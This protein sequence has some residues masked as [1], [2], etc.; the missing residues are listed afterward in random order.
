MRFTYFLL[1]ALV[2]AAGCKGFSKKTEIDRFLSQNDWQKDGADSKSLPSKTALASVPTSKESTSLASRQFKLSSVDSV[3]GSGLNDLKTNPTPPNIKD[4]EYRPLHELPQKK[5]ETR[6]VSANR[7]DQWSNPLRP[8][9]PKTRWTLRELV[10][11]WS[12]ELSRST[13]NAEKPCPI[14]DCDTCQAK[15]FKDHQKFVK[16]APP[17]PVSP[18]NTN[19]LTKT[20]SE[21]AQ[22]LPGPLTQHIA[23][24]K[25]LNDSN[26]QITSSP[27]PAM[28]ICQNRCNDDDCV[29]DTTMIKKTGYV[30]TVASHPPVNV[31]N[32]PLEDW[33][34]SETP[35]TSD[36]NEHLTQTLETL[37]NEV[38]FNM[39]NAN[40]CKLR[41]LRLLAGNI[42]Q[43]T[44]PINTISADAQLAFAAQMSAIEKMISLAEKNWDKANGQQRIQ[45][46]RDCLSHLK[47]AVAAIASH[48]PLEV[49]NLQACTEIRGFGQ[50]TTAGKTQNTNADV[51]LYCEIENLTNKKSSSKNDVRFE[52]KIHGEVEIVDEKG[53][54]I[55]LQE[56]PAI[57]DSSRRIRRDFFIYFPIRTPQEPGNYK[58]IARIRDLN[59]NAT[60]EEDR[61]V[62]EISTELVVR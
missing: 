22:L 31:I 20:D 16:A 44:E 28:S 8:R 39:D 21:L 48:A 3:I 23:E 11:V 25:P 49:A 52:T 40:P 24:Q 60:S 51:L 55:K 19:Q 32:D 4:L 13:A 54:R 7:S 18:A 50:Y 33:V 43:A 6:I 53:K 29:C 15:T 59:R 30:E 5:K 2:T 61:Q 10:K 41:L 58:V 35:E 9:K 36:W 42:V 47:E 26:L 34:N 57:K 17:K 14:I 45:L 12:G 56:F 27:V 1:L 46:F 38:E 62:A 37:S